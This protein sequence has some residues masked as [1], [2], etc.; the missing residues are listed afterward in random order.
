MKLSRR[1]LFGMAAALPVAPLA[2]KLSVPA[3]AAPLAPDVAAAANRLLT[4]QQITREAM[5]I[6]HSELAFGLTVTKRWEQQ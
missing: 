2:A 1:G 5:R 6:L 3:I 4:P